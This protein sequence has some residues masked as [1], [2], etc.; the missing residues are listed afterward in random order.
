MMA[1]FEAPELLPIGSF[2]HLNKGNVCGV[3]VFE[4]R[5]LLPG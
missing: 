3:L 5:L 1:T 4:G 2:D